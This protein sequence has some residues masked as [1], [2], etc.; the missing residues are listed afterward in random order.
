M[1]DEVL[2]FAQWGKREGLGP[3]DQGVIPESGKLK[4]DCCFGFQAS[5]V[6]TNSKT[7]FQ[8][9]ELGGWRDGLAVKIM[10]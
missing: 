6:Y 3:E 9:G 7:L 4:M 8:K 2:T 5:L 10:Y 1:P